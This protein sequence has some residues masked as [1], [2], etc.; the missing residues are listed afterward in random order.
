MS[1][2]ICRC[3]NDLWP[4]HAARSASPAAVF[5]SIRSLL[6]KAYTVGYNL[7]PCKKKSACKPG[8]VESNHSSRTPVT[9]GLKRPT[10]KRARIDAASNQRRFRA[11]SLFGLAPRGVYLATECCHRRGA[12][13]PHPFTLTGH[14]PLPG[15][16][17]GG[18]FSVAL[19]VGSRPPGVTWHVIRGSPDFPPHPNQWNT[20]D[21]VIGTI[22]CAN[23]S[24]TRIF[25]D[26]HGRT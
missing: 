12:L 26:R 21:A 4:N 25:K 5:L 14:D 20:A 24:L 13:L 2:N 11:A 7:D 18:L 17:L 15:N 16:D 6:R 19:S 8:S 1:G 3:H 9:R 22:W 23:K 10:R